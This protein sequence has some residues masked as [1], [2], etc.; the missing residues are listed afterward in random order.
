MEN[1]LVRVARR[2][3][4][5]N[6]TWALGASMLLYYKGLVPK[7]ND[8]DIVIALEHRSQLHSVSLSLS[9]YTSPHPPWV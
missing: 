2:L 1:C 8:I 9:V 4:E 3:N 7:A 5:E 6:I